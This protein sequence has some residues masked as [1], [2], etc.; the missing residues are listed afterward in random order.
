MVGFTGHGEGSK[1]ICFG[2]ALLD[3]MPM[4]VDLVGRKAKAATE[5]WNGIS[6]CM[7]RHAS[8]IQAVTA[9]HPMRGYAKRNGVSVCMGC[10]I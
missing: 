1:R 10:C 8:H 2:V 9:L 4:S 5:Y 7:G 6:G 3:Q